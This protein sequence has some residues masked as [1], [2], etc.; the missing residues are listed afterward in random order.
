MT[1][2]THHTTDDWRLA[3]H[4]F[5][6]ALP[7]RTRGEA[8]PYPIA[9]PAGGPDPTGPEADPFLPLASPQPSS[10]QRLTTA[11]AL[12]TFG[13]NRLHEAVRSCDRRNRD[14]PRTTSEDRIAAESATATI[15]RLAASVSRA[16]ASAIEVCWNSPRAPLPARSTPAPPRIR[17]RITHT[18]EADGWCPLPLTLDVDP[19]DPLVH[20]TVA[21]GDGRRID[22]APPG[23]GRLARVAAAD[24]SGF[25]PP[26]LTGETLLAA[27]RAHAAGGTISAT[28][29]TVGPKVQP[30]IEA[31]TPEGLA[32]LLLPCCWPHL[33]PTNPRSAWIAQLAKPTNRP[34][35]TLQAALARY[36]RATNAILID[37]QPL[38]P[39]DERAVA[40]LVAALRAAGRDPG[41]RYW[42]HHRTRYP[43]GFGDPRT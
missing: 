24:G 8:R 31:C 39:D 43:I 12:A 41:E 17:L 33:A 25:R 35:G 10:A 22:V 26:A 2:K 16:D 42:T 28:T 7:A 32:K 11:T 5:Y 15:E 4:D 6:L 19:T 34:R 20:P 36:D 1:D 40:G 21:G 3:Q 9:M 18:D 29:R 23:L 30:D 13:F 14:R 27:A 37:E 38:E